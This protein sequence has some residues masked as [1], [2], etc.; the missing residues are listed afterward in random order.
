MT[1]SPGAACL[2]TRIASWTIPSSRSAAEPAGV[3]VLGDAEEEDRRDAQLG[4]L[5]DRLA[6]PVERE[7]ILARHRGDLAPQVRAVVDEQR[8]DQVVDGQP[9]SRGPGRGAGDGRGAV[10]ADAADSRRRA[11]MVIVAILVVTVR[12]RRIGS[13]RT[14]VDGDRR[15][16]RDRV[17]SIGTDDSTRSRPADRGRARSMPAAV[18][19]RGPAAGVQPDLVAV[20]VEAVDLQVLGRGVL[21]GADV[22]RHVGTRPRSGRSRL[23]LRLFR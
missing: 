21:L 7:L 14:V 16:G 6:Q 2:A 13:S 10:G 8:V 23:R 19:W 22:D 20:G 15:R 4:H 12:S 17:R 1:S 9:R 11:G 3:L 18:P 5:G